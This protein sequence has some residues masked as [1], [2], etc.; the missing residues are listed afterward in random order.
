QRRKGPLFL[1]PLVF[2]Q[3]A[4]LLTLCGSK[5]RWVVFTCLC[6]RRALQPWLC[7]RAPARKSDGEAS[8]AAAPGG[9]SRPA[10][11]CVCVCVCVW[12][13]NIV[14]LAFSAMVCVCVCV[15]VCARETAWGCSSPRE[16]CVDV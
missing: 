2:L 12:P 13:I 9:R 3:C 5:G 6:P 11:V 4:V 8:S 1:S 7:A 10:S 15:C 16:G 14:G